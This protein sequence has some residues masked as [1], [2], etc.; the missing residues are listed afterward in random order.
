MTANDS[1]D[2]NK[3]DL[4]NSEETAK[5][6]G[7]K[8]EHTLEVWRSTKRYPELEYIKVG[9]LVRYKRDAVERFLKSRTVGVNEQSTF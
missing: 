1:T 9:R 4:L 6:I 3:N 8:N 5:W 2:T 7:L